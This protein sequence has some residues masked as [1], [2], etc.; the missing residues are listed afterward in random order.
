[1]WWL[2]RLDSNQL[3]RGYEPRELPNAPLCQISLDIYV[4]TPQ[5]TAFW[6]RKPDLHRH[7]PTAEQSALTQTAMLIMRF[8]HF[9]DFRPL[10]GEFRK[11]RKIGGGNCAAPGMRCAVGILISI[12]LPFLV[13]IIYPLTELFKMICGY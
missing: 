7:A 2:Q 4:L 12:R 10:D 1:M 11:E 9:A 8:L 3:P 5:G 6:C 13:C